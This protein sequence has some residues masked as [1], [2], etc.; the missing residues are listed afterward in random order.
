MATQELTWRNSMYASGSHTGADGA[1]PSVPLE[2]SSDAA[3]DGGRAETR[4]GPSS[5]TIFLVIGVLGA[6]A[7]LAVAA[8]WATL[9]PLGSWP[10]SSTR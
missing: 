5:T 4:R 2:A 8:T 6:S 10:P 3:P 9:W 1:N 7:L